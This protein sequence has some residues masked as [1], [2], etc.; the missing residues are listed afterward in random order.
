MK[1]IVSLLL[2]G[3]TGALALGGV[4]A[5]GLEAAMQTSAV[6]G[7]I[8]STLL[9][10][11]VLGVKAVLTR[12]SASGLTDLKMQLGTMGA[13]FAIRLAVVG[14]GVVLLRRNGLPFDGFLLA[15]FGCYLAQ[16]VIEV[17]YL[18][19][20]GTVSMPVAPPEVG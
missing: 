5:L 11:A 19:G 6:A 17:R 3:L 18:L 7:V 14:M 8:T 16:Q 4:L 15:F 9:G 13:S 1:L 12:V 10:A 2:V 20:T